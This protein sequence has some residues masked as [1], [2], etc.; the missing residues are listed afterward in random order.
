MSRS[1]SS[2]GVFVLKGPQFL[3]PILEQPVSSWRWMVSRVVR[4]ARTKQ[5][6]NGKERAEHALCTRIQDEMT[7]FDTFPAAVQGLDEG[8]NPTEKIEPEDDQDD[9]T[10]QSL[11]DSLQVR[12]Q[13]A[14]VHEDMRHPP[15]RTLARVLRCGGAKRRIVL[16]AA[17]HSCGACETQQRPA[18][19]VVSRS[20]NSVVFNDVVGLDLFS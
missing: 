5:E 14:R 15:N 17:K 11:S 13:I 16:A 4:A 12:R 19:P 3:S 7:T 8:E 20:P 6:T 1:N 2:L 10:E 9:E 18:G